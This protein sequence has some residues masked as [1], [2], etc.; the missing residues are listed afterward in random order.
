MKEPKAIGRA[1]ASFPGLPHRIEMVGRVGPVR[2]ANDSKA[3]NAD[4]AAKA[5]GAFPRDVHWILGGVPKAGG[6]EPLAPF[7]SRVACAYL[8]GEASDAFADTLARHGVPFERCGTLEPAMRRAL[9]GAKASGALEPVV[10]LSPACASFDQFKD[11]EERGDRFRAIAH[12][13]AA[14]AAQPAAAA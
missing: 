7:F 1:F 2:F 10:L 6:I 12:R 8:I 14:E 9:D 3:T 13:L 5:L 4:A 11:Y